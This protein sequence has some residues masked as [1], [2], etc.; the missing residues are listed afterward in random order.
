MVAERSRGQLRG[1]AA[2][3]ERHWTE[4]GLAD[5]RAI[6][7]P[8]DALVERQGVRQRELA[9]D[10][11]RVLVIDDGQAVVGLAGLK[12]L[13]ESAVRGAERFGGEHLAEEDGAL[14][15]LVLLHHH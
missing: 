14:P 4:R 9:E 8:G 2:M 7:L 11:V 12:E 13:W 5:G 10:I 3:H 15:K 6:E 1:R